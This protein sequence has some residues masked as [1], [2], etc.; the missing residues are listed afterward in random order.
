M[1]SFFSVPGLHGKHI[2][3]Q[4][5][6]SVKPKELTNEEK[7]EKNLDNLKK[8][9]QIIYVELKKTKNLNKSYTNLRIS[10]Q[11]IGR[12]LNRLNYLNN[13]NRKLNYLIQ[14]L[15]TYISYNYGINLTESILSEKLTN[16][17]KTII[18]K[19]LDID[20]LATIQIIYKIYTT[21][22]PSIVQTI[23]KKTKN[24]GKNMSRKFINQ[25]H[26]G[27]LIN[28]YNSNYYDIIKLLIYIIAYY[29]DIWLTDSEVDILYNKYNEMKNNLKFSNIKNRTN[30][31]MKKV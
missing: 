8:L 13:S 28:A 17:E 2:L 7:N 12:S 30:N 20:V 5:I 4:S 26:P 10:T 21:L 22:I 16:I 31:E 27:L 3:A 29:Y 23:Q 15:I 6:S 11:K 14:I 1:S 24:Y 9:I 19:K 18:D 25:Q